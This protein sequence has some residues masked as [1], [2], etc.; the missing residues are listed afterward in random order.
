M[1]PS[2]FWLALLSFEYFFRSFRRYTSQHI[3]MMRRG[4]GILNQKSFILDN[5][6]PSTQVMKIPMLVAVDIKNTLSDLWCIRP[7][8]PSFFDTGATLLQHSS[9]HCFFMFRYFSSY[10]DSRNHG[11]CVR[12]CSIL[13]HPSHSYPGMHEYPIMTLSSPLSYHSSTTSFF[14]ITKPRILPTFT[15]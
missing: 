12:S 3:S 5:Q 15:W 9:T 8:L 14:D 13:W 10:F 1:C 4:T 11:Q 2:L 6:S 7:T